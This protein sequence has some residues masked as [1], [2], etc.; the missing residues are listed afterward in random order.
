MKP[1]AFRPA[2]WFACSSMATTIVHELTHAIAAYALGVRSTL[3]NYFVQLDLTPAQAATSIPA[4]I[5]IAGPSVCFVLGIAAW[6]AYRRFRDS[7]V[8]L[9]LLF[10]AVFGAGTFFGNLMSASFI[11]DFSA[12]AIAWHLPMP[13]R[14]ALSLAGVLGTAAIHYRAGRELARWV[15]PA[16]GRLAGVLS[17][18]AAPVVLGTALVIVVNMPAANAPVRVAEAAFWIFA[19]MAVFVSGTAPRSRADPLRWPDAAVLLLT[20]FIV[21]LL[22]RGIPFVP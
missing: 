22:V 1:W 3:H 12:A 16:A 13:A 10:F 5:G 18:I 17:I 20:I 9:P 7:A 8:E 21:R 15:P 14:Y 6:V 11:G 2:A 4:W 19:A